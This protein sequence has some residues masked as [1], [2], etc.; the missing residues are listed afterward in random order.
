MLQKNV[1]QFLNTASFF[2]L[3]LTGTLR[4]AICLNGSKNLKSIHIQFQSVLM[5]SVTQSTTCRKS[6]IH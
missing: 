5:I 6:S 2:Y 1:E 4:T 3:A